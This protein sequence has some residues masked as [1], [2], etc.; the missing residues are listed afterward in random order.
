MNPVAVGSSI[1]IKCFI[2]LLNCHTNRSYFWLRLGR[3]FGFS[4]LWNPG[5]LWAVALC[6]KI[7]EIPAIPEF[8]IVCRIRFWSRRQ[9][10]ASG[11]TGAQWTLE[12][13]NNGQAVGVTKDSASP[14]GQTG[15]N[16]EKSP[17][18]RNSR[19]KRVQDWRR[20]LRNRRVAADPRLDPLL[21]NPHRFIR[22]PSM[23]K[24][25]IRPVGHHPVLI[26]ENFFYPIPGSY[27]WLLTM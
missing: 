15:A 3:W 1:T 22:C 4:G 2:R 6:F 12:C 24:E 17:V 8:Q 21:A 19:V 11:A 9:W 26:K 27:H 13:F 10:C 20:F 18:C 5:I 7:P 14:E 23:L 25:V 16:R